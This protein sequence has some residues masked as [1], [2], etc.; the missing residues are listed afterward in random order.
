MASKRS[1]FKNAS[2]ELKTPLMSIQ[3]YAEAIKDQVVEGH[4]KEESL[5][6]IITESQRLK[7]I[8]EEMILMTKLEDK[9]EAF[10][11]QSASIEE[12]LQGGCEIP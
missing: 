6:I 12:I 7:K 9:Q 2:H 10:K 8:V 1:F 4:E 5:D 3:G 11:L